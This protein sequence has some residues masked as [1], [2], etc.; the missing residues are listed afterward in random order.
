VTK[1]KNRR[2]YLMGQN[3]KDKEAQGVRQSPKGAKK[4][5]AKGACVP[6]FK[7]WSGQYWGQTKTPRSKKRSEGRSQN[8][9]AC[10]KEWKIVEESPHCGEAGGYVGAPI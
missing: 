8:K 2:F 9:H 1:K 3:D 5:N 4:K 6:H 10:G 7:G